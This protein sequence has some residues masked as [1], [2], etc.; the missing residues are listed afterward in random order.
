MASNVSTSRSPLVSAIE[1]T[2]EV[3]VDV[4]GHL[5]WTAISI[6][7]SCF[8]CQWVSAIGY[9]VQS[10]LVFSLGTQSA[11]T[12]TLTAPT[13]PWGGTCWRYTC[14]WRIGETT[15]CDNTI[16]LEV[17]ES[18]VKVTPAATIIV[19]FAW[20]QFLWRQCYFGSAVLN[21][22]SVSKCLSCSECPTRPA[23]PLITYW[24]YTVGEVNSQV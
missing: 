10:A 16:K 20:Y 4:I 13:I 18:I 19:W 3:I 12:W 1:V 6:D 8:Y 9:C 15:I 21:T 14:W 2:E 23:L 24:S 7:Q 11:A 5:Y 22:I 17:V